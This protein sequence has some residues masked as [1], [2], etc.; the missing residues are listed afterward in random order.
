MKNFTN[1]N[2]TPLIVVRFSVLI[3]LVKMKIVLIIRG[4]LSSKKSFRFHSH[5]HLGIDVVTGNLTKKM[6]TFAQIP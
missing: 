4:K 6:E 5:F 2:N 3:P 1:R